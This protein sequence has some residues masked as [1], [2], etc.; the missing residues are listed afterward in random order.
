MTEQLWLFQR[1]DL[2]AYFAKYLKNRFKNKAVGALNTTSR[3][4]TVR[5]SVM[6][7]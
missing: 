4:T 1:V 7:Q 6:G 2:L 5:F 3:R